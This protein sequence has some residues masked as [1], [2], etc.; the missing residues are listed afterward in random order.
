MKKINLVK[1]LYEQLPVL[2]RD[3][4]VEVRAWSIGFG[5][6]ISTVFEIESNQPRIPESR[7]MFSI[8]GQSNRTAIYSKYGKGEK[9]YAANDNDAIE[10]TVS[11]FNID[12]NIYYIV[13][14]WPIFTF[15]SKDDQCT[16]AVAM[17]D[18]EF[19]FKELYEDEVDFISRKS[20]EKN[21]KYWLHTD[22]ELLPHSL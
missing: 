2:Y 3:I 11:K 5:A 16:V 12:G 14:F 19:R 17:L 4:E 10:L 20:L 8:L 1:Q 7:S 6:V 15:D 18:F 22:S 13:P 21:P 9:C